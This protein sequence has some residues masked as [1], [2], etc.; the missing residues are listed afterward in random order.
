MKNIIRVQ[1]IRKNNGLRNSPIYRIEE[2]WIK[3]WEI[4]EVNTSIHIS[5]KIQEEYNKKKNKTENPTFFFLSEKEKIAKID[6][7]FVNFIYL[8]KRKENWRQLQ[9]VHA[10]IG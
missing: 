4:K 10:W 9:L 1:Q 5:I 7:L 2:Y 6:Q 3:Y 8:K